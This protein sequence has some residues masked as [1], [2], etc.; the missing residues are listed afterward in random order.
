MRSLL[1][2]PFGALAVLLAVVVVYREELGIYVLFGIFA[3][4]ALGVLLASY[5]AGVEISHL[6]ED[7]RSPSR[8]VLTCFEAFLAIVAI[9]IA[10][11]RGGYIG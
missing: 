8:A 2:F 3:A 4:W 1:Y 11:V 7:T 10:K 9:G 5:F 6:F